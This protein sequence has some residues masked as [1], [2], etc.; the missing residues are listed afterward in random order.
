ML[1]IGVDVGGTKM[2]AALV[3]DAGGIRESLERATNVDEAIDEQLTSLIQAV[4]SWPPDPSSITGIGVGIAGIIDTKRGVVRHAANLNLRNL[5]LEASLKRKLGLPVIIE[6]DAR[7][8]ASGEWHY[9]AGQG[10]DDLV[11]LVIGTGVGIGVVSGGKILSNTVGELGHII[12]DLN[13]PPCTCGAWGCFEA[14]AGGWAIT[15]KAKQMI[16]DYPKA[17]ESIVH[18]AGGSIEAVD[19]K[20]VVKAARNGNPL[21]CRLIDEATEAL[22]AGAA[23]LVNAFNPTRVICGG[24]IIDGTPELVGRIAQGVPWRALTVACEGL[25]V[26]QADLGNDAGTIGAA[27]LAM[28]KYAP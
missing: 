21:A 12:L 15:R 25:Q 9:G 11:C 27:A 3:D 19:T 24:G 26:L 20:I 16:A 13:G 1:A 8:I 14:F 18:L 4:C 7:A 17:G 2:R 28:H 5:P 6:N 22:I 23:S 10:C